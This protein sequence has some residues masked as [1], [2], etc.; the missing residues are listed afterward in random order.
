MTAEERYELLQTLCA[1]LPDRDASAIL[2][3][4]ADDPIAYIQAYAACNRAGVRIDRALRRR[5]LAAL[6]AQMDED[7]RQ[8]RSSLN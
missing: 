3:M 5:I 6:D 4:S 1:L 7:E 2:A 8:L